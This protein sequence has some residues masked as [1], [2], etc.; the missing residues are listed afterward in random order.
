MAEQDG[1]L[2]KLIMAVSLFRGFTGADAEKFLNVCDRLR[3]A[4]DKPIFAQGDVGHELYIIVNGRVRIMRNDGCGNDRTLKELGAGDFF[5]EL[6]MIDQGARSASAIAMSDCIMLRFHRDGLDKLPHMRLKIHRNLCVRISER[7]RETGRAVALAMGD[8]PPKIL[9]ESD[10]DLVKAQLE[11]ESVPIREIPL[12][13]DMPLGAL[14]A[15]MALS[16][17][18][19]LQPGETLM[20]EGVAATGLF[21]MLAGRAMVVKPGSDGGMVVIGELNAGDCFGEA[22]LLPMEGRGATIITKSTSRVLVFPRQALD[23]R[24]DLEGPLLAAIC[25]MLAARLRAVDE[26]LD[27]ALFSANFHH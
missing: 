7:I 9:M 15:F 23:K 2:R 8:S 5:G 13:K 25:S 1:I 19:R 14:D 11:L 6:A 26:K 24:P 27:D 4:A 10:P 12:L 17:V 18:S 20:R 21:V 3:V 22:A 16:R